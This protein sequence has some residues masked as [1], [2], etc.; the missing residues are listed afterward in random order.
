MASCIF[1]Q[2]KLIFKKIAIWPIDGTQ[3]GTITPN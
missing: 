2:H 1:I 3:T